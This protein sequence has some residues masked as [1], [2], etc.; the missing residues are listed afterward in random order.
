MWGPYRALVGGEAGDVVKGMVFEV[1]SEAQEDLLRF[2]EIG[3]YE[4]VECEIE[5]EQGG[6][7]RGRTFRWAGVGEER[8]LCLSKGLWIECVRMCHENGLN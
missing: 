5:I 7:L 3:A 6:A 8:A 1:E 4:V 2:Y